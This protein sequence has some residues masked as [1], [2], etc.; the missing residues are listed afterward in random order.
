MAK[1]CKFCHSYAVIQEI[2]ERITDEEYKRQYKQ[3]CFAQLIT[4]DWDTVNKQYVGWIGHDTV[5][6][7]FCPLCGKKLTR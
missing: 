2:Q 5:A 4:R 6:L 3:K 7:K 1:E